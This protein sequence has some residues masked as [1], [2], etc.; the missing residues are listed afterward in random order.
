LIEQ[1]KVAVNGVVITEMGQK[2]DPEADLVTIDGKP[3][4]AQAEFLYIILHKP[5]GYL[6]TVSDPFNRPTVMGLLPEAYNRERIYPVGRLDLDTTGLLFFTNDGDL[7]LALAHPR[8]LVEKIYLA[9]VRGVPASA[10]LKR[11]AE[12]IRLDDGPTAPAKVR[13]ESVENG[14]AIIKIGIREGRNRQ[15]KRMMVAV[16][17]PVITLHRLAMGPLNLEGLKPGEFRKLSP[18]ELQELL[19]LKEQLKRVE[20]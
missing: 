6:T 10:E 13:L 11:L 12:G 5:A 20:S 16:G 17:H 15:I 8:H 9:H 4:Q 19:R 7:A 3:V 18:Q 14:N 1:G 2:I